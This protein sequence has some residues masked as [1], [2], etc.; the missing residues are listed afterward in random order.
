MNL[1]IDF[2]NTLDKKKRAILFVGTTV[3]RLKERTS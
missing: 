1:T 2:F 3:S